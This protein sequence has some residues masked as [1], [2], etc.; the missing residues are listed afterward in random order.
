[1][2]SGLLYRTG[3]VAHWGEDAARHVA[4]KLGVKCYVDLRTLGEADKFG[5]P[6]SLIRQ[7]V[8]WR[9]L[10]IDSSDPIFEKIRLPK[11]DDWIALYKV[12]FEKNLNS[13]LQF[14]EIVATAKAPILYGCL[15]GKDRTGIATSLLLNILDVHDKHISADYAETT[16]NIKPLAELFQNLLYNH[17][18][19]EEELFEHY[20]RS[21]EHVM[22]GFLEFLRMH[23]EEHT[24]GKEL[25]LLADKYRR[26]LQDRLL[27]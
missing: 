20:S 24:I 21:H 23:P 17:G 11:A 18:A 27:I 26:P 5:R 10:G 6:E 14:C 13:W 8:E 2:K 15:F 22:L 12:I 25:K 16:N 4:H 19:S 7:G 3:N 1:M 9:N